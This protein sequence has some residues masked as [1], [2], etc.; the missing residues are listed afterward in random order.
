VRLDGLRLQLLARVI[1]PFSLI[2]LAVSIAGVVTHERA[3][4]SLVTDRDDRVAQTAAAALDLSLR[5]RTAVLEAF[6]LRLGE[7]GDFDSAIEHA[8]PA[9]R[10]FDAGLAEVGPGGEILAT[11]DG[12]GDR[13]LASLLPTL[14]P[15]ESAVAAPL[16]EGDRWVLVIASSEGARTAAGALSFHSLLQDALSS[17]PSVT[18]GATVTLVDAGGTELARLPAV[19]GLDG[20]MA[21][22]D[23]DAGG[24]SEEDQDGERVVAASSVGSTGWILRVE[25]PWEHITS[26]MLDLSLVA[27]LVLIPALVLTLVGLGFGARRVIAPL[28]QLERQAGLVAEGDF[29]AAGAPVDGIAEVQHLQRTMAWMAERIGAAQDALQ[30]YIGAITRA[31]EDERRRLARELHDETIQRLI[32]L[33]QR[34]QIL[35]MDLREAEPGRADELDDLHR[36]M[37]EAIQEVRRMTRAL[38][39]SYLEDLGLAPALEML[40]RDA[41]LELGIR[42]T[43]E[44]KGPSRRLSPEAELALYRIVQQ[45]LSNIGRHAQATTAHV[46]LTFGPEG[47]TTLVEDDG[48][49]FDVPPRLTDL[50][51]R[52][53]FGLMGMKE[54]A[55]LAGGAL[56]IRSTPGSGTRVRVDLPLPPTEQPSS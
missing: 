40:A 9:L 12:W 4:R 8:A 29:G 52:G 20:P 34:L 50:G 47:L 30:S 16:R 15:G 13:S 31:Q 43:F 6:A 27:P 25:E 51:G 55:E 54:R 56:N 1:L 19:A 24:P 26:P 28:R 42:T 3:M 21:S 14:D 46:S 7:S 36:T 41:G 44:S 49:G 18:E 33:D 53:H 37:N 39:P 5:E 45:A 32:A 2:L 23:S 22:L 11:T 48:R 38:R 10:A 17:S 35:A